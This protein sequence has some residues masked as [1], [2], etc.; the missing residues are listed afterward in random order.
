M[1]TK[2]GYQDFNV[3]AEVL[4]FIKAQ[5]PDF[6]VIEIGGA[7][8]FADGHLDAIID[9]NPPLA[10]C[11]HFFQGNINMPEVWEKL[12]PGVIAVEDKNSPHLLAG[13]T[14]YRGKWDFAIC[15]HTLEDIS[16]PLFVCQMMSKIAKAGFIAVPSKFWEM[17]RFGIDT[18]RG[19]IHHRWIFD[20][21]D[22]EFLGFPKINY[23]ENKKF[24][25][26]A[27]HSSAPANKELFV[28]WE[29]DTGLKIINDDW[30]GPT[31]EAVMGYYDLLLKNL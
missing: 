16:N 21:V 15:T 11:N 3:R 4:D 17:G 7:T 29:G 22:G 2:I 20:M 25:L 10:Q 5:G 12:Q 1:I 6:R 28:W 14:E 30:L 31:E 18:Y 26:V 24:D 23:I 9:I 13:H 8:S 19:F 27:S